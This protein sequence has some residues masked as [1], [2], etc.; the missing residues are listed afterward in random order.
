MTRWPHMMKADTAAAYCD[1]SRS[2]FLGEVAKGR[3]PSP[4]NLGG[5]DHWFKPALDKSLAI[6]A[7]EDL[8]EYEQE[9]WNR[10]AS[11]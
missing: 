4:I 10:A 6:I 11:A 8:P 5:R 2:A 1:L 7:G 3:L 9:F